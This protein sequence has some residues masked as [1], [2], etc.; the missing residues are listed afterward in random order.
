MQ[1]VCLSLP[2]ELFHRIDS[3]RGDINRSRYVMRL[4]QKAYEM[5][6]VQN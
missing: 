4:I 1:R 3:E 5:D 2:E 6:D